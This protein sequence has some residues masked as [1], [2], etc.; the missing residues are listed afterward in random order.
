[1][2]RVGEEPMKDRN[3]IRDVAEVDALHVIAILNHY[4]DHS[5]ADYLERRVGP[6]TRCHLG[7]KGHGRRMTAGGS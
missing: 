7:P 1:M 2:I 3:L 4:I 5:F 6:G